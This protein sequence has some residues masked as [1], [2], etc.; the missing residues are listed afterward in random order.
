VAQDVRTV[1][2]DAVEEDDEG[3]LALSPNDLVAVLWKAVQELSA[4]V[5]ELEA[6]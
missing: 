1:L 4:R 5:A 6:R 3:N 2:P